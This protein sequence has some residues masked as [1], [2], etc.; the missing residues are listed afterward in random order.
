MLEIMQELARWYNVN[1]AF[2]NPAT[3]RVRLH[4]VAERS[5]SLAEAIRQLNALGEVE[6]E[7]TDNV[8]SI[9]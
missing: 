8:V 5:G 3:T 2:D 1:V 4:F 6:V 9:R 7:L